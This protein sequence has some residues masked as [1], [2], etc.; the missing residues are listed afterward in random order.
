MVSRLLKWTHLFWIS[1]QL[2][3][4]DDRTAGVV[5][6]DY[7]GRRTQAALGWTPGQVTPSQVILVRGG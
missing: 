7:G 2:Y 5:S 6:V 4:A 1:P 3:G